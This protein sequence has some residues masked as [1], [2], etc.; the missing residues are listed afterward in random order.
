MKKP[1]R[2]MDGIKNIQTEFLEMKTIM[3]SIKNI[4]IEINNIFG[5]TKEKISELQD[6]VKETSQI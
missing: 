3:F 4:L 6:T 2:D 5:M 1:S